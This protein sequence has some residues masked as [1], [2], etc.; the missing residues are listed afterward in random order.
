MKLNPN[1][2]SSAKPAFF[3]NDKVGRL[4]TITGKTGERD[5]AWAMQVF[6]AS[7]KPTL[8]GTAYLAWVFFLN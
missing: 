7:L 8:N 4:I 6:F 1:D 2:L 3:Q 5:G